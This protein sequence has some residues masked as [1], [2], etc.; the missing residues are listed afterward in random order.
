MHF[1]I[2]KNAG[3]SLDSFLEHNF[4]G[5]CGS[6]EGPQPWSTLCPNDLLKYVLDH[7]YLVAVSSHQARLPLPTHNKIIF[8]PLLFLRHPIDRVESVY[9][10]ERSQSLESPSLG[11]KIAREGTL[12]EYVRW[13]LTDGNGAVIRNFQT[14][15]LSGW[16]S[17]M[18]FAIAT[19][20]DFQRALSILNNLPFF[21]LVEKFDQSIQM[22]TN[23]L[24]KYFSGLTQTYAFRNKSYGR[25]DVLQDRLCHI[26]T[27]LGHCLYQHL[28]DCNEFDLHL[29][30]HALQIF[31]SFFDK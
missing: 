12:S 18:R 7:P 13:R 17:D 27:Q 3:S 29:Y 23:Y 5:F 20:V 4:K 10:F 31:P 2:F 25:S 22:A 21:G 30:D 14:L 24:S 11:A 19:E 16:K 9:L 26:E 8:H 15:F 28:I 1:H 6:L